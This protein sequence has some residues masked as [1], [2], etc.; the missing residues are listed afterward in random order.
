MNT[1]LFL[2]G[3]NTGFPFH[4][5]Q[6]E[7]Q[8]FKEYS[9]CTCVL[10]VVPIVTRLQQGGPQREFRVQALVEAL[11]DPTTGLTYTAPSGVCSQSVEDAKHL[12]GEGVTSFME[13]KATRSKP[14]T[15][16]P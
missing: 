16:V 6:D 14:N 5:R 13:T 9:M 8:V 12:F 11:N 1:R 4:E 3:P 7:A 10:F 15:S 2:G